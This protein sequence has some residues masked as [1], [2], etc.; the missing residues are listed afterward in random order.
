MTENFDNQTYNIGHTA[1]PKSRGGLIAVLLIV[2]IFLGGVISILG[3]LNIS[4]FQQLLKNDK[5]KSALAVAVR[6][7]NGDASVLDVTYGNE[8]IVLEFSPQSMDYY[9]QNGGMS[10]Q[11]IYESTVRSLVS[12]ETDSQNGTGIILTK[13]GYILTNSYLLTGAE[14]INIHLSNGE[15]LPAA[16]V[17]RDSFSDLAILRVDAQELT[18]A[19][20]GDSTALRVGDVVVTM[21]SNSGTGVMA[22]GIVSAINANIQAGGSEITLIQTSAILDQEQVGGMLI[23]C[24]GQI[25]GIHTHC[26]S[27]IM[28]LTGTEQ[29]SFALSSVTIK[30]IADQLINHGFVEGRIHLGIHGQEIDE[31]YQHY[32]D[33]PRGIFITAIEEDSALFERGVREGDILI[34]LADT[35]ILSFDILNSL[36]TSLKQGQEVTAV[37]YRDGTQ[38]QM[39]VTIGEEP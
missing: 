16:V 6:E 27:N 25:V 14:K 24:H 39:K 33:I 22:D 28:A 19:T 3:L 10:L 21:G 26:A 2:I 5:N 36:L 13:D 11:G 17:G 35:P 32:Y 20:F 29:V 7:N 34:N 38:Y 12:V 8:T 15:K 37:V 1:P 30:N 4:L 23:N 18:P 31:F 9:P